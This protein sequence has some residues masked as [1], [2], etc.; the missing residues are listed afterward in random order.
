M[1]SASRRLDSDESPYPDWFLAFM[2]DRA[3]RKPS[4]HTIKAYRQD[5]VVIAT[6]L[7]GGPERVAQLAPDAIT[8]DAIQTAFATSCGHP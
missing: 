6:L 2:A 1:E 5:F 8:K 7:A 3:I 4:P